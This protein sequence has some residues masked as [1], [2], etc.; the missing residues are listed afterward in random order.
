[1]IYQLKDCRTGGEAVY[2]TTVEIT[3]KDNTL[4][5]RFVAEHSAYYCPH[6]GYNQI[7]SEGDACEILI[8]ADPNRQHYYEIEISP[9]NDLMVALMDY[10]GEDEK[11]EPILNINFV[12][13]CFVTSNVTLTEGGYIAE[14]SFNKDAVRK[15]LGDICYDGEIYFN[16]YRLETDGGEM[17]KHLFAMNPTMRHKFHTP[18]Y[19]VYLKD[20][21]KYICD[22]ITATA[23]VDLV[24]NVCM[25]FLVS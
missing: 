17:D 4:T 15:G 18:E 16:A 2:N 13:D 9:K 21:V 23:C 1:M 8:G 7:H 19:Y 22:F 14:V 12:E 6:S 10:N 11:D 20:Y 3:E 5:F 24:S 25:Q